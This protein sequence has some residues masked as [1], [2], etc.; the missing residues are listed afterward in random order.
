MNKE[1]FVKEIKKFDQCSFAEF[2][3]EDFANEEYWNDIQLVYT[4]HPSI[5]E[6]KGKVQIALLY[7]QFG[8]PVIRDMIPRAQK[9]QEIEARIHQARAEMQEASQALV[10]LSR[11]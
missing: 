2:F 9:A 6:T 7:A 3:A 5:S 11:V 10:K 8:M 4:F 1:E